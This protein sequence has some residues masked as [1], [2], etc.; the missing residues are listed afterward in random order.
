[1]RCLRC[2]HCCHQYMVVIVDYPPLGPIEG[3]LKVHEGGGKPCPHLRGD[4]PGD[5]KCA[6]HDYDWYSKTPCARH[7][8]IERSPDDLCRLGEYLMKKE[9][10][11]CQE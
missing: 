6:V 9:K 7:G 2:G 3:N 10:D 8:Q 4:K 1:M 5:Y 11:K